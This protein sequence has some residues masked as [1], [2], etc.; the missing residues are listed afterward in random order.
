MPPPSP[1]PGSRGKSEEAPAHP[2]SWP[3]KRTSRHPDREMDG[4][5]AR[6]VGRSGFERVSEAEK[7]TDVAHPRVSELEQR[8]PEADKRTDVA[9]PRVSELEQ[10][11][12]EAD[13]RTHAA[14]PRMSELEERVPEAEKRTDV[15]HPR[16]SELDERV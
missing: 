15:A 3:S 6:I 16:M 5:S 14:H 4:K 11:V 8:V 12:P 10:R 9:H 7:R 1:S 2:Y 13:K